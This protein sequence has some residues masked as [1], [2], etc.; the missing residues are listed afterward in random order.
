[1]LIF[2]NYDMIQ[3]FHYIDNILYIY[4]YQ[5]ERRSYLL[6]QLLLI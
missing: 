4:V 2:V 5:I 6:M 1:M 3:K